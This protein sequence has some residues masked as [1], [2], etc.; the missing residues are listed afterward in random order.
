MLN[1]WKTWEVPPV[2]ELQER[3][4]NLDLDKEVAA[5]T[6]LETMP[7]IMH[8]MLGDDPENYL[9]EA[10]PEG[11]PELLEEVMKIVPHL[12]GDAM[13]RGIKLGHMLAYNMDM[14]EKALK[15]GGAEAVQ[16]LLK[17]EAD[18]VEERMPGN[19][20]GGE[21]HNGDWM[22]TSITAP[23]AR[24]RNASVLDKIL[25]LLQW[26][27]FQ[28]KPSEDIEIDEDG[29]M[30]RYQ[31]CTLNDLPR[32]SKEVFV[33]YD[34]MEDNLIIDVIT[35]NLQYEEVINFVKETTDIVVLIDDSGSMC[36]PEKI[37]WIKAL[38]LVL[39]EK[40]VHADS[41]LFIGLF[42]THVSEFVEIK[43]IEQRDIWIHSFR[44]GYGGTTD[45]ENSLEITVHQ[46]KSGTLSGVPEPL[47][48]DKTVV[49]VINDGQ[50]PIDPEFEVGHTT[51]AVALMDG[52]NTGVESVCKMTGGLYLFVKYDGEIITENPVKHGVHVYDADD[53]EE[54]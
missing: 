5:D 3:I 51:H 20:I 12:S 8:Q 28:A 25:K 38:I 27:A 33:K 11:T 46:I 22:A 39:F 40:V 47:D 6:V 29:N 19:G 7:G 21:S 49:F 26:E 14:L 23:P 30:V 52:W 4:D 48:G 32:L 16:K 13:S 54:L 41:R 15:S 9:Q 37:A 1:H 35:G 36:K 44:S 24:L 45:I 31:E 2:E 53:Y 17:D 18:K 50:D 34:G 42:E 10:Y 43:T